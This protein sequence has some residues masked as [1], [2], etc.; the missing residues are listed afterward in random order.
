MD[1]DRKHKSHCGA[2]CTVRMSS[3]SI[4]PAKQHVDHQS[5]LCLFV[6]WRLA[7]IFDVWI[8]HSLVKGK[9]FRQGICTNGRRGRA[10][11]GL[12]AQTQDRFRLGPLFN[13]I[14]HIVARRAMLESQARCFE[15]MVR[16]TRAFGGVRTN[17][18]I[19]SSARFAAQAFLSFL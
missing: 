10:M 6:A 14:T 16:M 7:T 15:R 8:V 19:I 5:T 13:G 11:N 1:T 2:R 4:M 3:K 18:G 9:G 12:E 17:W